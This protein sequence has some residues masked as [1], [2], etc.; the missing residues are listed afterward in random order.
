MQQLWEEDLSEWIRMVVMVL[1]SIHEFKS[2][3]E[4]SSH[5]NCKL[6]L[7]RDWVTFKLRFFWFLRLYCTIWK[8][9]CPSNRIIF[10]TQI[11]SIQNQPI[12]WQVRCRNQYY[13]Y[14]N[15]LRNELDG[16][17]V[18][19]TPGVVPGGTHRDRRDDQ[20]DHMTGVERRKP[21]VD[22]DVV[23]GDQ[24][25]SSWLVDQ[26]S[27]EVHEMV[28]AANWCNEVS[29]A[30]CDWTCWEYWVSRMYVLCSYFD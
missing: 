26:E 18:V 10:W 12:K 6:H 2:M 16:V 21:I 14:F 24:L 7:I 27:R 29:V 19:D 5:K 22:H 17:V 3:N 28:A 8:F 4:V 30:V 20:V 25:H 23:D 15:S 11:K 13:N 1:T 9:F